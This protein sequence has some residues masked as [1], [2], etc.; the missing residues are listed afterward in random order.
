MLEAGSPAS[1]SSTTCI[2]TATAPY[3]DIAEMAARDR[4]RAATGI[5]LTLLPVFYAHSGNF[6]GRRP[7]AGQRRFINDL[8]PMPGCSTERAANRRSPGWQGVGVAP[9]SLRAVTAQELNWK[10]SPQA[11]DRSTSTSP[12]RCARSRTASPSPAGGRSNWLLANRRSTGAG[13]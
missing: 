10:S 1:A 7:N 4:R 8:D 11:R 12:S 9:H 3:A 2:T 5:G 6:G 13:A